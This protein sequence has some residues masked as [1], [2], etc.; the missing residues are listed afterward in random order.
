[1]QGDG[2]RQRSKPLLA[3]TAC[4]VVAA[5]AELSLARWLGAA[6]G[7][8]FYFPAIVAGALLGA[9]PGALALA[10][11]LAIEGLYLG[12]SSRG[13]A[14]NSDAVLR[15]SIFAACAAMTVLIVWGYRRRR[16]P[17]ERAD[18][19]FR[20]V[21][22]ISLEGIVVYRALF[23]RA[24]QVCDFEYRYANPAARAI[25]ASGGSD[26]IVGARLLER[27]PLAREHP[28]LFPRYVRVFK[29]G[30]RS[31]TEY[32]LGGRWFHSTAARLSDGLVVTVQD[33]SARRR[34]DEA[35]NLLLQE[36]NHRVRNLLGS[37]IAMANSTERG[38]ASAAE[39][40]DK[41]TARLQALSRAHGL[42]IAGAWTDAA[43]G[44][45]VNATGCLYR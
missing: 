3:A 16:Q 8:V 17:S 1:V 24:G 42:L 43:V 9:W 39:F 27:L 4:V 11:S 19:L 26:A 37:V 40:R 41:L 36:L 7:L 23:D 28:L 30:E 21:Q 35:R 5:A 38:A 20:T 12:W 44:E 29:S 34:G 25:M 33:V 15:F 2:F 31:E 13:F 45:V 22:D 32:E 6:G 18:Q 10:L 14:P